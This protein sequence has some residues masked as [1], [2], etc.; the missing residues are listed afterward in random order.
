[1]GPVRTQLEAFGVAILAAVL[2]KWFCI[3]AFQIPTSSMQPTLM[4]GAGVN[5]RILVNKMLQLIR[6]PERWDIT[7]FGY[8]LQKNQNYV[9][10]IGGMPGDRISILGGNLYHVVDEG[11]G[12]I[13]WRIERK[14]ADL[15]AAMWK[16]VFPLRQLVRGEKNALSGTLGASPS[17]LFSEDQTGITADLDGQLARLFFRDETDGGMIDRVWDGYPE[18]VARVMRE[19]QLQGQGLLGMQQEI[20]PDVRIRASIVPT[21]GLEEL[22]FELEVVR[23]NLDALSYALVLKGGKGK[24]VVRQ[25]GNVAGESPEFA[26][27]LPAGTA[28][29]VAFAHV[30]DELIAWRDG[31]ELQRFDSAKWAC[32]DGC[33]LPFSW[34]GEGGNKPGL[35]LPPGP[36]GDPADLRQG[37][38]QAAHRR[39]AHRS[40]PAL[41]PQHRTG[42]D[43]GARGPLLHARRQH[44][45]VDRLAR[46]DGDHDRRRRERQ[47]G[48]ARHPRR[49]HRARQQAGDAAV[50]LARPRRDADRDPEPRGAG[51]DRRVRRDLEPEGPDRRSLGR[52]GR[53]PAPR[54]Q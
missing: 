20:V 28:T 4:G 53:V 31:D 36:E 42:G 19:E 2:L 21:A 23:P 6:E 10:R 33:V 43:R 25:K 1:M 13:G 44:A 30:D 32:R 8:P 52:A 51:D 35:Q 41:H 12:K 14:P 37:Q 40:R 46:L 34:A 7:V 45:A 38:G 39:P 26:F 5:D 15:Q 16:N 47:R 54:R 11:A 24:L 18:T 27:E 48:A 49:P 50:A 9:K 3:E 17:R 22:A 29:E